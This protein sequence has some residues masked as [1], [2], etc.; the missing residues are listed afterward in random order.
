M[1][2]I[3]FVIVALVAQAQV[4]YTVIANVGEDASTTIRL[5]WHTDEGSGESVCRYTLADDVNWE[6]AKEAK[7]HQELCTIFDSIYSKSS[8]NADFYEDA[9]FIRNT[10]EISSL[11][12]GTQYKYYIDGD[13]TIRYFKTAPS[14]NNWTAA[15]ISDF[16]AYAP[17]PA[18]TSAGMDMLSTLEWQRGEFDMAP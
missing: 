7:A 4:P 15:I 11:I 8:T 18:R 9:R 13:N 2:L 3:I 17:L 6:Y 16:H 14:N 12:P 10:L 5:N 1:S